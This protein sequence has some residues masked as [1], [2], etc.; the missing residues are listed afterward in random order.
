MKN[1]V[2]VLSMTV[3]ALAI[4]VSAQ[5]QY[6]KVQS[7]RASEPS[8]R[9][10][11]QYNGAGAYTHEIQTYSTNGGFQS[12]KLCKDCKSGT[13]L[14][15]GGSYLWTWQHNLQFGGDVRIE[16]LSDGMSPSGKS[17]TGI[18]LVA[19]AVYNFDSDFKNSFYAKGGLGVYSV[20]D[21]NYDREGKFG[22]QIG[23]GKRFEIF[24][25]VAFT[26]ELN[27]I[28]RGDLDVLIQIKMINL[29]IMFN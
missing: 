2:R 15:L 10:V 20:Y 26:P 1:L 11:A 17:T 9:G 18:D 8:Y 29:S 19:L 23:G 4:S 16:T 22:L 12:G 6:K 3:A 13:A 5:A 25:N 24:N 27:L 21:N 7:P 28:Q 14:V